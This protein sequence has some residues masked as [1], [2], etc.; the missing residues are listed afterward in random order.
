MIFGNNRKNKNSN[1]DIKIEGSTLDIVTETKFV[2]VILDNALS[3]KP[4]IAYISKQISKSIGILSRACQLLNSETL[5]QLYY[6]FLFPYLNY[7]HI[8]DAS[9]LHPPGPYTIKPDR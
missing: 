1:L 3:W 5:R 7:C 8:K 2:G 4:H 6:S 9:R